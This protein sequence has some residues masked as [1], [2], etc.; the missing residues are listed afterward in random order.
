MTDYHQSQKTGAALCLGRILTVGTTEYY[1]RT[2][3]LL[4]VVPA[5]IDQYH[6]HKD[7]SHDPGHP[8]SSR[9]GAD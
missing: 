4:G 2:A 5:L 9:Q 1:S 3:N 6:T 7:P 8:G